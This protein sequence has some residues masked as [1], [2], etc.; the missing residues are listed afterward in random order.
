MPVR[1]RAA[2]ASDLLRTS[3]QIPELI[4]GKEL[5]PLYV[6]MFRVGLER[7]ITAEEVRARHGAALDAP[8]VAVRW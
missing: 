4:S 1:Y 6:A 2:A 3:F 8:L 5:V 7:G